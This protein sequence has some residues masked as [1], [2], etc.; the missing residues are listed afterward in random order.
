MFYLT[1]VFSPR[2]KLLATFALVNYEKPID[3]AEDVAASGLKVYAYDGSLL[4][5]GLSDS[6]RPILRSDN[7][8]LYRPYSYIQ[9]S[10]RQ[11]YREQVVAMGG[12][13]ATKNDTDETIAKRDRDVA[14][15]KALIAATTLGIMREPEFRL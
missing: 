5:Q 12:L 13:Y 11:I 14:E 7:V 1:F 3:T 15:G 2:S 9:Y 10:C 8:D 4:A 6:Y